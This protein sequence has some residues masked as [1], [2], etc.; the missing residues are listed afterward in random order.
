MQIYN[1]C[2]EETYDPSNFDGRVESYPFDDNHV[3][4]LQMIKIF[5]ESVHSWLSSDP[6]NI[7]A[8]HCMVIVAN[9]PFQFERGFVYLLSF[10]FPVVFIFPISVFDKST[11]F[12]GKI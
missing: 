11:I 12:Y 7:V 4:P 1:L 6:K 5:C 3:P 9:L 10:Q 8:V 2:I